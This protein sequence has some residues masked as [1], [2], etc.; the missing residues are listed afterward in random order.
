MSKLTKRELIDFAI[1]SVV[2]FVLFASTESAWIPL[3]MYPYSV[4][5]FYDGMTRRDLTA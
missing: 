3:L 5:K 2:V 4:W 1:T